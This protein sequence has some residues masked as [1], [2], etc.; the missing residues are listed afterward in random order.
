M[1]GTPYPI[2]KC[3]IG[4]DEH[5]TVAKIKKHFLGQIPYCETDSGSS[6]EI[7]KYYT[8]SIMPIFK[9][10]LKDEDFSLELV[11]GT[12]K[13]RGI[14][15]YTYTH[16]CNGFP[17]EVYVHGY[18]LPIPDS[19]YDESITFRNTMDLL[20]ALNYYYEEK[21]PEDWFKNYKM[22]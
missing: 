15:F 21:K 14:C 8:P 4:D 18:G 1:K 9:A 6:E 10:D 20:R 16:S 11:C 12:Y 17:H 13:N 3:Y 7:S 22:M 19:L 5:P 2:R